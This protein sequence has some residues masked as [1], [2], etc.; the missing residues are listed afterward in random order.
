MPRWVRELTPSHLVSVVQTEYQPTRPPEIAAERHLR[1]GVHDISEPMADAVLAG[2]ADVAALIDFLGAWRPL[3]G[4]L[5]VH[6]YAGISRSTACALVAHVM[7]SNDPLH[8]TAALAAAA[9]H[10]RPNR[11]IVALADAMLGFDG[12]LIAAR[13]AMAEG[14]PAAEGPLAVLRLP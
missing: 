4:S 10:A 6:C 11:R 3:E 12:A 1:L 2:E 7:H 8:S 5:L 13:A 9:P 14:V